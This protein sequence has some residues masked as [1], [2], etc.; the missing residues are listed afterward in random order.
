MIGFH[1]N[2]KMGYI[3]YGAGGNC[4]HIKN[5]LQKAK[6]P[7]IAILDK[8]AKEIKDIEGIPVY[9]LEQFS[10]MDVEKGNSIIIISIKNVFAHINIARELLAIGYGNIIYKPFPILQGE[11]DE[12]WD[13]INYAYEAVV[14]EEDLSDLKGRLI[15][16]SRYDHLM[17]FKD[18]LI[19]E[20]S[21]EKVTCWIPI[22]LVCNYDR[23][24]AFKLLPMAA[25]YPLLNLYQY[26]LGSAF[27][28]DWEEIRNDFFLYAVDWVERSNNEFSDSLKNSMLNSRI[29]IFAEMQ[30]KADIDKNFFIRNAVCVKRIDSMRFYLTASGRNRVSFLAAKGY[31]FI[32]AYMSREDYACWINQG[33]FEKIRQHLEKEKINELFTMVPHPFMSSFASETMDYVSLFCMQVVKEIYRMLH[34]KSA[35][36]KKDYFKINFIKFQEEKA[37]LNVF[38]AVKDDGCIGRLLLMYGIRCYRL[39][40]DAKQEKVSKLIDEL[41]FIEDKNDISVYKSSNW[42]QECQILIV[43]SRMVSPLLMDFKGNIIFVLQWGEDDHLGSLHNTFGNRKL[44]FRTIWKQEKVSG[45]V[46]RRTDISLSDLSW[47]RG[48]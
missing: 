5:L 29:N 34:W 14:E 9:T 19:I 8:R 45:W 1:V 47:H 30:K 23:E 42:I 41:L 3:I 17:V 37:N 36:K 13:S 11:C 31:R 2:Q 43:D 46:M 28:Y 44:L 20:E 24:D 35:E 16:C 21:K 48:S 25:Y 38:A 32:P 18:E 7:V 33:K 27:T 15:A 4:R 6:Y 40:N 12:E 22:E 39:Y 26:L 10:S